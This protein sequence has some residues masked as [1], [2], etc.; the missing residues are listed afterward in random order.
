[1]KTMT[2]ILFEKKSEL[3]FCFYLN[4]FD[5]RVTSFLSDT[6][7]NCIV[8]NHPSKMKESINNKRIHL[9]R[10][11]RLQ[12]ALLDRWKLII[13]YVVFYNYAEIVLI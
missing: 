5:S 6:T 12:R 11:L 7:Y 1:M 2:T 4:F 3:S 9:G 8:E 10:H 13:M